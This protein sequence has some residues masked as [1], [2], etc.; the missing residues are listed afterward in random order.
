VSITRHYCQKKS[1][2]DFKVETRHFLTTAPKPCASSPKPL[3]TILSQ[4]IALEADG[5]LKFLL[6]QMTTAGQ[7]PFRPMDVGGR[8]CCSRLRV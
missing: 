2:G 7:C 1:A 4:P 5:S 3:R 6:C 8:D